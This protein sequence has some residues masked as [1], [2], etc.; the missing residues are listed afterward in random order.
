MSEQRERILACACLIYLRDGLEGFSMRKL[1]R[2]LGVTAPAL[3][4]HYES[5]ER[6]LL[7]VVGEGYRHLIQYLHRALQ[8]RTPEDRFRMA[9][10][11]YLD[12]ALEYPRYYEVLF[13]GA[14]LLGL[15]EVPEEVLAQGCAVGQFW[16]DRVRETI[17]VGMLEKG[18]PEAI[19]I[20]LWAHTH[21]LIFPLPEGDAGSRG[22]RIQGAVPP[23][24]LAD[25]HRCR[26]EGVC[27]PAG[28]GEGQGARRGHG[29]TGGRSDMD[30]EWGAT[31]GVLWSAAR[32]EAA[33]TGWGGLVLLVVGGPAR[34]ATGGARHGG[35]DDHAPG[36]A[37]GALQQP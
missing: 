13:M 36:G 25:V 35:R 11:G 18:D 15:D 21:G 17:E 32:R 12:F 20:T 16:N 6:V 9:G 10:D 27:V 19:G 5:K 29:P 30:V 7:D 4:R 1:A 26:D 3:Y 31:G 14:N 2:A 23:V 34:G 8:G 37:C 33:G 28:R 24:V 22:E